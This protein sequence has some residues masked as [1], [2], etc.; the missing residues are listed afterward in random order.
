MDNQEN[1]SQMRELQK[2]G[3]PVL[4]DPEGRV[5]RQYGVYNL[6]GDGV[7]APAT[8]IIDAAGTIRWSYIGRDIADRPSPRDIL[9]QVREVVE[10]R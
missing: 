9:T 2:L 5:T 7:A 8:F 10:T 4:A 3:F 1:A 6:L